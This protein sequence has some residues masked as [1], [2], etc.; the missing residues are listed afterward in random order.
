M[1]NIPKAKSSVHV[2]TSTTPSLCG[3][4]ARSLPP[5]M[6]EPPTVT[7][8]TGSRIP[9]IFSECKPFR[10]LLFPQ[11]ER[12]AID[13][14]S[15]NGYTVHRKWCYRQTVRP[16]S[17]E[18][19][20]AGLRD[21][22]LLLF[23]NDLND[24]GDQRDQKHTESKKLRPCNHIDHPLSLWIGGKEVYPRRWGEPPTVTGSTGSRISQNHSECNQFHH[25]T[26]ADDPR[27]F[28]FILRILCSS[29]RWR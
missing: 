8:S 20:T 23:L 21:G 5:Q 12:K 22:R 26:P 19:V 13:K 15:G 14:N 9:Q 27:A 25:K 4:G 3:S 7:G 11:E 6:G 29:R 28:V 2:I 10:L 24:Q 17:Y 1:M 16:C 18:E